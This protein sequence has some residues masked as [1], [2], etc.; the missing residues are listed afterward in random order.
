MNGKRN[1]ELDDS[2]EKETVPKEGPGRAEAIGL[3]EEA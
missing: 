2:V 1:G 3:A